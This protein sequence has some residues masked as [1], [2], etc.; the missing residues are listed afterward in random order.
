MLAYAVRNAV[1]LEPWEPIPP[2]GFTSL[3]F[4]TEACA[5]TADAARQGRERR[6]VAF[7]KDDG[8]TIVAKVNLSQIVGGIFGAAVLGYSVDVNCEGKG[9]ASEAVGAVVDF[10]F[11]SLRLHRVEANYQPT[12]ERSGRLLRRLGFTV[13]GYARD[14]L[15]IAGAWRDHVL[16]SRTNP[17][18][19]SAEA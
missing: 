19:S 8:E 18:A 6:F 17:R 5:R 12:N 3:S 15:F 11:D 10:A 9:I 1:H 16:T 7:L 14:Y 4:W 13:E 2:A